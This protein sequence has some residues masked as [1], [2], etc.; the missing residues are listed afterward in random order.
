MAKVSY[1]NSVGSQFNTTKKMEEEIDQVVKDSQ[2]LTFIA[3]INTFS[4]YK[5]FGRGI[6]RLF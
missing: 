5:V 4:L 1:I 3:F 6:M 2:Q